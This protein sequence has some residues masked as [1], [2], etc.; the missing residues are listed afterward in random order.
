MATSMLHPVPMD[1]PSL[2]ALPAR[3][4]QHACTLL[5]ETPSAPLPSSRARPTCWMRAHPPRRPPCQGPPAGQDIV[6]SSL[7]QSD[8]VHPWCYSHGHRSWR[9]SMPKQA[10]AWDQPS[11]SEIIQCLITWTLGQMD[12]RYDE[13]DWDAHQLELLQTESAL[14]LKCFLCYRA[15]GGIVRL[16]PTYMRPVPTCWT[17]MHAV[18]SIFTTI[19]SAPSL[20]PATNKC[21]VTFSQNNV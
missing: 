3:Q 21:S 16:Y 20:Q 14:L 15:H 17:G 7:I 18:S 19:T 13:G 9:T 5:E 10:G 12:E 4:M 2:S 1:G 11:G 6:E 8:P